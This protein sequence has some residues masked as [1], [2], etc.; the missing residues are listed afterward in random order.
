ME[1]EGATR[2]GGG[3]AIEKHLILSENQ[4]EMLPAALISQAKDT[5]GCFSMK[6]RDLE[7]VEERRKEK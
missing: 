5:Q 3:G 1:E 4:R 2:K 6:M 7:M